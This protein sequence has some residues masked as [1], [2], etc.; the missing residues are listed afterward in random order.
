MHFTTV[1]IR[2]NWRVFPCQREPM[3]G[4]DNGLIARDIGKSG[5]ARAE[6]N[7]RLL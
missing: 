2:P 1:E 5:K 6:I 4:F 7:D 3:L